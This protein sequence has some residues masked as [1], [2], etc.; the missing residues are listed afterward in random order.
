MTYADLIPL[1]ARYGIEFAYKYWAN[2]QNNATPTESS[3]AELRA[4]AKPYDQYIEEARARA[5]QVGT[6]GDGTTPG[7]P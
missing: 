2:A 7:K 6:K 4:L 5:G 1:I 3:W